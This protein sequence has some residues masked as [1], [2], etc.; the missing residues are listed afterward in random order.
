MGVGAAG[1][2]PKRRGE[3]LRREGIQVLPQ[4]RA[5]Q[6]VVQAG[7]VGRQAQGRLVLGGGI[8]PIAL[9]HQRIAQIG[10][11]GRVVGPQL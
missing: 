10:A 7:K 5:P 6:A 1:L 4:P 3:L 8:E 9:L 11:G 2:E